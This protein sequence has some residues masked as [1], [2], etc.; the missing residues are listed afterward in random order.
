[1]RTLLILS[2]A[3]SVS[4]AQAAKKTAAK[5]GHHHDHDKK[6]GHGAHEHSAAEVDIV[7]TGKGGVIEVHVPAMSVIG[8]E[9]KPKTDADKMKR[10]A[11]LEAFKAKFPMMVAIDA[12]KKCTYKPNNVHIDYEEDDPDHSEVHGKFDVSCVNDPV[13]GVISFA[14]TK[15]YPGIERVKVQLLSGNQQAGAEI[16]KDKGTLTIGK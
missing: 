15:S 9:Y 11:A 5:A 4:F 12:S 1:M 14:F 7:I 10:D 3:L 13:G 6:K 2:L 16:V 8:F